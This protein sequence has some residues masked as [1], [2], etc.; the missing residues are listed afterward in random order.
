[1]T[2][3]HLRYAA[4]ILRDGGL[5]AYPTE[6]V[7]GI[8][9]DPWRAEAVE[10]LLLLKRR[11]VDKG[12]IL[13]ADSVNRLEGVVRMDEA[14]ARR[15][16]ST[17]PGPVTWILPAGDRAPEWISGGRSTLAVRV[18]A[19]PLAA[20]LCCAF[21]GPLVS[22]SANLG[23]RRPA[24]T[25]LEVRLRVPRGG[26]DYILHGATGGRKRPTEIRDGMTGTVLR[27]G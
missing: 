2:P 1:M 27:Q 22:T 24:R 18:T 10:R 13:I 25:P 15:T 7:Y 9:C 21:G 17:W 6:G 16:A 26:L 8:G 20:L 11:H 23:G 12:M 4:R 19:H 3:W 14:L 5:V